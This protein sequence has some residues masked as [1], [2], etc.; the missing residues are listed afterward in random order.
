M[1]QNDYAGTFEQ[2][3]KSY[4]SRKLRAKAIRMWARKNRKESVRKND[5]IR[6]AFSANY[7]EFLWKYDL[8]KLKKETI[9][10]LIVFKYFTLTATSLILVLIRER[11]FLQIL[12]L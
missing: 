11:P 12:L 8:Q 1:S 9:A 2:F 4:D 6:D 3:S 5:A 10:R 7:G